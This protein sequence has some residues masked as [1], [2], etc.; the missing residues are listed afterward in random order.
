[1]AT[2]A[3]LWAAHEEASIKLTHMF[4]ARDYDAFNEY[5]HVVI[6]LFDQLENPFKVGDEVEYL[7]GRQWQKTKITEI[8]SNRE[9]VTGLVV[10]SFLNFRVPKDEEVAKV[11]K[12]EEVEQVE[13][14]SLFS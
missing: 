3:E 12:I 13:Q 2:Q 7:N 9:I 6:E 14:L 5:R 4:Y 8:R 10:S 1:M 11:E